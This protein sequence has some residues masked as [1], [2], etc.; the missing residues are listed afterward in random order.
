MP[1]AADRQTSATPREGRRTVIIGYAQHHLL[2]CARRRS[3]DP[4]GSVS[5]ARASPGRR[6]VGYKK[7][8]EGPDWTPPP[9]MIARQALSAAPNGRRPR[10]SARRPRHVSRW[11]RS[12]AFHAPTRRGHIGTACRPVCIRLTNEDVPISYSG[13]NVGTKVIVLPMDRPRRQCGRQAELIR[14]RR[15]KQRVACRWLGLRAIFAWITK[16]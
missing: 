10:Q 9:E 15:H 13:S 5:A 4:Y 8:A 7:K 2:L 14:R 16:P 3:G 12:I 11:P 6:A 1:A